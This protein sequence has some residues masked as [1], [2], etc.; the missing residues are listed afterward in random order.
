MTIGCTGGVDAWKQNTGEQKQATA[1][2]VRHSCRPF[3]SLDLG[4]PPSDLCR[5]RPELNQMSCRDV[6]KRQLRYNCLL[7]GGREWSRRLRPGWRGR[8]PYSCGIADPAWPR[9]E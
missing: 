5:S 2:R 1:A 9:K 4:E 7:A 6:I 3:S 8:G